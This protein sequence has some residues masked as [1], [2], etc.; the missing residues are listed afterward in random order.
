MLEINKI[1]QGDCLEVMKDID[2]NSVDLVVTD[3]PYSFTF[4]G[5]YHG[6]KYIYGVKPRKYCKKLEILSCTN[7]AVDVFLET[8]QKK[9]KKFNAVFCCNKP[10]VVK[11]IEF[12]IK[13]NYT[14]DIH[15]IYKTNPL[16]ARNNHY[17]NNLEYIIIIRQN[18][19]YFDKKLNIKFYN[20]MFQTICRQDPIHPA[21]KDIC[22]IE[23]YIKVQSKENDIILDPYLGSGT[24]AIAC[25]KQNR[26][27]IGIE[28]SKEYCDIANQRIKDEVNQLKLF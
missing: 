9:M 23:K 15:V 14:Y 27:Y 10:L 4:G 26:N 16:P 2:D 19:A 28:Q 13:N 25:I 22:L 5:G 7:F 12:A 24:T 18:G 20:K 6:E 8:I 11:Y 1:Y 3:P 21:Q 17:M